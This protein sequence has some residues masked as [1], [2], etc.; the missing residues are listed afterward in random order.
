[1]DWR[2]WPMTNVPLDDTKPGVYCVELLCRSM[3]GV[4]KCLIPFDYYG[5]IIRWAL[6]IL[7]C[8]FNLTRIGDTAMLV[9]QT[10]QCFPHVEQAEQCA[11]SRPNCS[12]CAS[13]RRLQA[14]DRPRDPSKSDHQCRLAGDCI[15]IRF[16]AWT[17]SAC[18]SFAYTGIAL[19]LRAPRNRVTDCNSQWT[20]FIGWTCRY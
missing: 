12:L 10:L 4:W 17:G 8:S 11:R 7:S 15:H 5:R 20:K 2:R 13:H 16:M 1:M 3:D 14:N 9:L 6:P 19:V 18:Y